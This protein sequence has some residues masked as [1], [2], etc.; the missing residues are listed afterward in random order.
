MTNSLGALFSSSD[1]GDYALVERVAAQLSGVAYGT[2]VRIE[3]A[4]EWS[5]SVATSFHGFSGEARANPPLGAGRATVGRLSLWHR[6]PVG[7]GWSVAMEGGA[8]ATPWARIA[9]SG[10]LTAHVGRDALSLRAMIGS[11]SAEL[12]NYRAFVLGG[13][14][15]LV[16][17]ED[18]ALGGRR[19]AQA[20]LAWSMPVRIPTPRLTNRFRIQLPS[21]LSLV[22]G[23]GVAG[24]EM[25]GMPW[26][27]TDRIEPVAG[28]RL[29]LW[30][31]LLRIES[32]VSLRTG[33]MGV[34][35]DLHPAWWSFF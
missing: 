29:D 11:G 34:T 12:P 18:R 32:G 24:G 2:N 26:Q 33:H 9:A 28:L 10:Q 35:F 3:G 15:S 16:G 14:G 4:E 6:N 20:E 1:H 22:A 8:S 31:P 7:D 27:A 17:I 21:T 23:A 13:R 5:H 19:M 30:G 25:A